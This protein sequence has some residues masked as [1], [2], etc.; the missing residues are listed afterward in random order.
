MVLQPDEVSQLIGFADSSGPYG[1]WSYGSGLALT[2]FVGDLVQILSGDDLLA[3]C[4]PLFKGGKE[5]K[6]LFGKV[7]FWNKTLLTY[8]SADLIKTV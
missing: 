5:I 6:L 3:L 7:P 2:F 4:S 1:K 8:I